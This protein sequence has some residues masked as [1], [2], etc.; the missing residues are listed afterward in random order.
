MLE[1][2]QTQ[3]HDSHTQ[4][5]GTDADIIVFEIFLLINLI[6]CYSFYLIKRN[7]F[8]KITCKCLEHPHTSLLNKGFIFSNIIVVEIRKS[9]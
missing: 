5:S 2:C 4:N 3:L 9:N 1:L 8:F 7:D 6:A